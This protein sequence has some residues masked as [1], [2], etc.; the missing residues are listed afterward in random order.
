MIPEIITA[1]LAGIALGT[2]TGLMPGIHINL[3]A[4]I[5][6]SASPTLLKY[7]PPEALAAAIMAMAITHSFLDFIPSIFIGAPSEATALSVLPGHKMLLQGKGCEA[8]TLTAIGGA[9]GLSAVVL[10]SPLLIPLVR[11]LFEAIKPYIGILLA[12]IAAYSIARERG[13]KA[14]LW[15]CTLFAL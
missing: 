9:M 4:A 14:K 6:L 7:F 1:A 2:F 10:A 8:A 3:L 5:I 15:A 13:I 12:G 11:I